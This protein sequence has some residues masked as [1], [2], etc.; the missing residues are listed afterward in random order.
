MSPVLSVM[1][2]FYIIITGFYMIFADITSLR[3]YFIICNRFCIC[4]F[5]LDNTLTPSEKF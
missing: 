4:S 2:N 1:V 5:M 3:E